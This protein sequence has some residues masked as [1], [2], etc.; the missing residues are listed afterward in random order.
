MNSKQ[1]ELMNENPA[2]ESNLLATASLYLKLQISDILKAKLMSVQ[3]NNID[4]DSQE[5]TLVDLQNELEHLST[6]KNENIAEH[7]LELLKEGYKKALM[8]TAYAFLL[9]N[10]NNKKQKKLIQEISVTGMRKYFNFMLFGLLFVGGIVLDGIGNFIFALSLCSLISFM[11]AAASLYIAATITLINAAIFIVF[12][13][14]FV[15]EMLKV[16]YISDENALFDIYEDQIDTVKMLNQALLQKN[17]TANWTSSQLQTFNKIVL[18]LNEHLKSKI[19]SIKPY[20]EK[21]ARKMGRYFISVVGIATTIGGSYFF[22]KTLLTLISAGLVG[23]PLGWGVACACIFISVA[24]Y[25]SKGIRNLYLTINS[26][27]KKIQDIK[28][29]LADFVHDNSIDSTT[30]KNVESKN[31]LSISF[32]NFQDELIQSNREMKQKLSLLLKEP[33]GKPN[34]SQSLRLFSPRPR[35]KSEAHLNKSLVLKPLRMLA[36]S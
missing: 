31:P 29:K 32:K 27:E 36:N 28:Q 3:L 8:V 12:D 16:K 35:S 4:L 19:D 21:T 15:A 1:I 26:Q 33:H 23:T 20:Q 30:L 24:Y 13:A 9:G 11:P 5:L 6:L 17:L 7:E 10:D 2:A 34:T 18:N 14:R 22:A 25:A